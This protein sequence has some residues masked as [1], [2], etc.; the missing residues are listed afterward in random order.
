MGTLSTIAGDSLG[1]PISLTNGS[2]LWYWGLGTHPS[3]VIP[4]PIAL[5]VTDCFGDAPL[6]GEGLHPP[7]LPPHAVFPIQLN[8]EWVPYLGSC[9][10]NDPSPCTCGTELVAYPL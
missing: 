6:P 2:G 4:P 10:Y 7:K 5:E 9:A 3:L 8:L 1:V